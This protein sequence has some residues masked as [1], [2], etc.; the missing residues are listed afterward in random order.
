MEV[1]NILSR[2]SIPVSLSTSYLFLHPFGIS[3][4]DMKS[5]GF[6]LS[7]EMSCQ[8]FIDSSPPRSRLIFVTKII[9]YAR[10]KRH[11]FEE[12]SLILLPSVLFCANIIKQIAPKW[13]NW[14]TRRTQNPVM[15]TSCGF[16]SRLRHQSTIRQTDRYDT[17]YFLP[18]RRPLCVRSS[19]ALHA[20]FPRSLYGKSRLRHTGYE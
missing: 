2:M 19:R 1:Y 10:A 5:S 18:A 20:R 17:S 16:K 15:A 7:G 11:R 9:L 14:Q 8:M 3:I 12:F 4:T 13:W 6:I